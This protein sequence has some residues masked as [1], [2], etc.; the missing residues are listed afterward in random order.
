[1]PSAEYGPDQY[2]QNNE[3]LPL[4][5]LS[6]LTPGQ[7]WPPPTERVRLNRY[8]VNRQL[9]KRTINFTHDAAYNFLTIE[10]RTQ[11]DLVFNWYKR[12]A[13]LWADLMLSEQPRFLDGT[14]PEDDSPAGSKKQGESEAEASGGNSEAERQL[15]QE[16]IDR[17]VGKDDNAYVNVLYKAAIDRSRYGD[18]LLKIVLKKDGAAFS[19]QPPSYWFPVVNPNDLSEFTQHCLAWTFRRHDQ[20]S[21]QDFLRVEIH[22]PGIIAHRI[23][24]LE[25]NF[26]GDEMEI[27]F[28]DER[29]P[30]GIEF[31]GV[32]DFMIVPFQGLVPSDEIFGSDDYG[33]IDSI[34]TAL[35]QRAAQINRIL[36]IHSDPAMYGPAE[37]LTKDE[38]GNTVFAAGGRYFTVDEDD[39]I[40]GY[41]DWEPHM[42]AQFTEVEKLMQQLYIISE[43]SPAAFG[44]L[45]SGLAES[46]SALRRLMQ[47]PLAKVA[48]IAMT[49]DPAAKRAIKLAAALERAHK[50]DTPEIPA[51]NIQWQDG[52]PKDPKETAETEEIRLRSGN[53]SLVSSIMRTDGSTKEEALAE[54]E[55]MDEEAQASA[56]RELA[57]AEAQAEIAAKYETK[58]KTSPPKS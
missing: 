58:P 43:T 40:P 27:S 54:I 37:A 28:F 29:V 34:V 11:L 35:E 22:E 3:L 41:I 32:D 39:Q 51:V 6:F 53:T 8:A 2:G 52:L 30:T 20:D 50:R 56:E 57:T 10:Q 36:K 24:K 31:T 45:E 49:F 16:A 4:T 42:E 14:D 23:F 1:M 55:R 46:G 12:V 17:I 15:R 21:H 44:Q 19:S 9:W 48:R 5:D 25:G 26:I 38:N 18:G 47:A 13:T 33:D 7:E